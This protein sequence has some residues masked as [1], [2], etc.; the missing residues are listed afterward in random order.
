MGPL[1]FPPKSD[2]RSTDDPLRFLLRADPKGGV[3]DGSG[4]MRLVGCLWEPRGGKMSK[5]TI[6]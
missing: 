2:F 3:S 5:K 4:K 1:G 6:F